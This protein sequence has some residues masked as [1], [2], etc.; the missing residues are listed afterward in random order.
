MSVRF[1]CCF[2]KF[3]A[4]SG[5]QLECEVIMSLLYPTIML[6]RVT[7][8]TP[9]MLRKLG[10]KALI[11]DADNT[12]TTH[13]NPVP[14]SDVLL[15]LDTMRENGIKLVIVSNNN[16]R[17]IRPFAQQMNLDYT[18][19][20]LKPLTRGFTATARRLGL[21]PREIAVVGDQIFTDILGGNLF[22]APTILVEPMEP[23]TGPLFRFK[24]KLEVGIL[25]RYRQKRGAGT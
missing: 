15:W 25:R 19:N 12:L 1:S 11:L 23:E 21:M 22:G 5:N 7:G 16:D 17:R 6:R 8:I 10:V 9:E 2:A 20:A 24:R 3:V 14:D 4:V 13:N 18:A